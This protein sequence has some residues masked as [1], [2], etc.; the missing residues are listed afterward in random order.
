MAV[1]FTDS[2]NTYSSSRLIISVLK[3]TIILK[4]FFSLQS[5]VTKFAW[6]NR[7]LTLAIAYSPATKKSYLFIKYNLCFAVN[8]ICYLSGS[9]V[10][11]YSRGWQ[12]AVA[13]QR[14]C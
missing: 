8:R 5:M 12:S 4:V 9:A 1:V 13:L 14:G 10:W 6:K 2:A 7:Q 3:E 11:P